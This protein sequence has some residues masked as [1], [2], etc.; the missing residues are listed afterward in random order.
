MSGIKLLSESL[1]ESF[2]LKLR[3]NNALNIEE[4]NSLKSQLYSPIWVSKTFENNAT[5]FLS[6]RP[7]D[8]RSTLQELPSEYDQ[9]SHETLVDLYTFDTSGQRNTVLC[10]DPNDD[11][12][13]VRG[14]FL[15]LLKELNNG[16]KDFDINSL[17]HTDEKVL[18][19]SLESSVEEKEKP[20]FNL[21]SFKNYLNQKSMKN[22]DEI[23]R[24]FY[25]SFNY[26]KYK[27]MKKKYCLMRFTI[28]NS[29]NL[30]QRNISPH[31][32][33]KCDEDLLLILRPIYCI[34]YS[35]IFLTVDDVMKYGWQDYK[36]AF[37][38]NADQY[39]LE[40]NTSDEELPKYKDPNHIEWP[41]KTFKKTIINQDEIKNDAESLITK[42]PLIMSFDLSSISNDKQPM[43]T[44]LL[45]TTFLSNPR[46]TVR[47]LLL[48]S[49]S[50]GQEWKVFLFKSKLPDNRI[51]YTIGDRTAREQSF[52]EA[53]KKKLPD[54]SFHKWKLG[55][56][57]RGL[58]IC[59][60][61][62]GNETDLQFDEL[63][64]NIE[65]S[66]DLVSKNF[67]YSISMAVIP[68]TEKDQN[69]TIIIIVKPTID[70]LNKYFTT[71]L[72]DWKTSV[73]QENCYLVK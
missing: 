34:S 63:L 73:H 16:K 58:I 40:L 8:I 49:S 57:E 28:P 54:S 31:E 64:K 9:W 38:F 20:G 42:I 43:P 22:W 71:L 30:N 51:V 67:N 29:K 62:K 44:L 25:N 5:Y 23:S 70:P 32:K 41:L 1:Y 27:P 59:P 10:M 39:S 50:E 52:Y 65:I 24:D 4:E 69:E 61:A 14:I 46:E 60:Q 6:T 17:N 21:D 35:G 53:Y 12:E 68:Q 33:L 7:I 2:K 37:M 3:T 72:C 48:S 45:S 13:K 56:R 15:K 18:A 19:F 11:S 26:R 66:G 47:Q 36:N 55:L